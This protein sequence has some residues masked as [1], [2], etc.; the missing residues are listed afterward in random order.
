MVATWLRIDASTVWVFCG[1]HE[2]Y[3]DIDTTAEMFPREPVSEGFRPFEPRKGRLNGTAANPR[4][5]ALKKARLE[6]NPRGRKAEKVDLEWHRQRWSIFGG[7]QT[8]ISFKCARFLNDEKSGIRIRA[9]SLTRCCDACRAGALPTAGSPIEQIQAA[10]KSRGVTCR[11]Q[12][13]QPFA[14][15]LGFLEWQRH[16]SGGEFRRASGGGDTVVLAG[17]VQ[18]WSE[19]IHTS[20]KPL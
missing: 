14:Q 17:S 19:T 16:W 4:E 8:E 13:L 20:S 15:S 6:Y 2:S 5:K 9:S 18:G 7:I 10:L 3:S 12:R 11:S 1:R